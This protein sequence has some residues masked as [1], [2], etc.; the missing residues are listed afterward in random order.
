[1][2]KLSLT[3]LLVAGFT[4][5]GVETG[6]TQEAEE[7]MQRALSVL[8]TS[9]LIDTHNDLP[10]VIREK[11]NGDVKEFDLSVR[12]D[13]DTD[14][15][16]LREG[17]VG[18]QFWSVW[19][20][21]SLSPLDAMRQQLEQIDLA[22]RMIAA[23]ADDF[24]F[25]VS[26]ADI[27]REQRRGRIASLIGIEGGHSMGNSLGALRAYYDLGVRYM[28][29]THFH[30]IDW[31]DSATDEARHDGITPFGEEVVREMNRLGMMV[32]ISHVSEA[33]MSDVLRVSEAPVIFSHSSAR[34]VTHHVRNVP[35]QILK[36]MPENGGVVMVAFIPPFVSEPARIWAVDLF[37]LLKQAQSDTEWQ[38]IGQQYRAEHGS[39]PRATLSDVADH[40]DHIAKIAGVDHVGIGA[41]FY[42]AEGEDEL[43]QGLEDVSKYPLLFAE[44]VRRGWSDEDLRKLARENLLRVFTEVEQRASRLRQSESPSLATIEELDNQP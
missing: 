25:A 17:M 13:L 12:R 6:R 7:G 19:V 18:T 31:A 16:R 22:R 1:M 5:G 39:P 20:P 26:A 35:D 21:S 28:T 4:F 27:Q 9:P 36:Q 11:A 8:R 23:Y 3:L 34:A 43:V 15:P 44:L 29:L 30:T 41:D 10:W 37:P 38:Q 2:K 14:I 24:G 42:G 40:I 32:D 33:A